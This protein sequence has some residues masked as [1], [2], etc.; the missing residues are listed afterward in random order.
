MILAGDRLLLATEPGSIVALRVRDGEEL[1]SV[2]LGAPTAAGPV[3]MDGRL[4]VS[5]IRDT[6]YTVD[7]DDGTLDLRRPLS[8]RVSAAPAVRG[9]MVYLPMQ[10][11]HIL[12]LEGGD[13]EE[14]WRTPVGGP[15][16]AAPVVA[17]DGTIYALSRDG[18]VWGISEDG[19]GR[20]LADLGSAATGALTVTRNTILVGLLDGRVVALAREGGSE[21]WTMQFGDSVTT[22]PLV[23]DGAIY[24]S[25]RRGRVVKIR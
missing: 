12:A 14:R 15:V 17:D 21:L 16:L 10:S 22:P 24:V 11:G 6:L 19:E 1:W 20:R 18:T 2:N 25:L 9:S 13:L 3:V 7:L 8:G 23:Q 4:L 5:S